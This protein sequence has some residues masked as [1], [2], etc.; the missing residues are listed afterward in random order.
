MK[1]QC[2]TLL[3][4]SLLFCGCVQDS[5]DIVLSPE[6]ETTT[7]SA[8]PADGPGSA[9]VV[10]ALREDIDLQMIAASEFAGEIAAREGKVVLLD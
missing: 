5:S 3:Y 1:I 8:I 7:A 6:D 10:D 2:I 4:C 9:S